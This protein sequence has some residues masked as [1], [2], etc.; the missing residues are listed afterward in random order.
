MNASVTILLEIKENVLI[1][2]AQ[3]VQ[4]DNGRDV[5]MVMGEDQ[6]GTMEVPVTTGITKVNHTEIISGVEEGQVVLITG[7]SDIS[8]PVS[9]SPDRTRNQRGGPR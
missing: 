2:P 6:T 8:I 7:G 4:S 1:V 5:V 3:A 9:S